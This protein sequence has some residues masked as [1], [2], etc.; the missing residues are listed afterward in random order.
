L[1]G[2]NTAAPARAAETIHVTGDLE[3]LD[4]A[5]TPLEQ[6]LA[7]QDQTA[8]AW[9]TAR[10]LAGEDVDP[11]IAPAPSEADDQGADFE[12]SG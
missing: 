12:V 4:L 7:R 2:A 10:L 11:A 5:R 9:I 1:G 6:L 3:D 8:H